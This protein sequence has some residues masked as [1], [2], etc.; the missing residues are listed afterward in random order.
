MDWSVLVDQIRGVTG[1]INGR[2]RAAAFW[3]QPCSSGLLS[4]PAGGPVTSRRP[5]LSPCLAGTLD[6]QAFPGAGVFLS[7]KQPPS[8][9]YWQPRA[10]QEKREGEWAGCVSVFFHWRG[11]ISR[12]VAHGLAEECGQPLAHSPATLAGRAAPAPQRRV[13]GAGEVEA[14]GGFPTY[15]GTELFCGFTV[16]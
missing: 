3:P 10:R 15:L 14:V 7:V 13:C 8:P 1:W 5:L 9:S 4:S 2:P 16:T 6:P 12:S 11:L